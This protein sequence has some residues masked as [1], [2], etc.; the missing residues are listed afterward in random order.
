[1]KKLKI[2]SFFLFF[3]SQAYSTFA[4]KSDN[5]SSFNLW[6]GGG[7]ANI[8]HPGIKDLYVLGGHNGIYSDG[9]VTKVTT[10]GGYGGIIGL[11]YG[12]EHK[13]FIFSLGA[14]F[15][16]KKSTS[17]FD[18]FDMQIG[19]VIDANTN[20]VIKVGAKITPDM[21]PIIVGG[22]EAADGDDQF[23]MQYRFSKFKE[24]YSIGYINIPLLLGGKF[25]NL[26]FML[27]GKFG[28]YMLAQ[29]KTT[30]THSSW[31]LY[32]K[33]IG[34]FFAIPDNAFETNYETH[35]KSNVELNF[36]I[37]ASVEIGSTFTLKGNQLRLAVFAD[38]SLLN[39]NPKTNVP[40]EAPNTSGNFFYIP[41]LAYQQD[42]QDQQGEAPNPNI[43]L[44]NSL[45]SSA[46]SIKDESTQ[47]K[48]S[49]N[50]LLVGIKLTILF[51][52]KAKVNA[53]C[54]AVPQSSHPETERWRQGRH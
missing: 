35:N 25:G 37:A 42:Q 22:F 19:C 12:F 8:L 24:V 51:P 41:A 7:Y 3:F 47:Q 2:I 44:H 16:F 20:E 13:H 53:D 34:P 15:D 30:A 11:G 6:L 26:Y 32:V 46:E 52:F 9:A 17:K 5:I 10:I 45:L 49:V 40:K 43:I 33:D 29:A 27:G 38:Y 48:Y 21:K 36:N 4:Q 31:A 14:E 39:V 23:E 1:M 50:P 28:V 54:P 18:D